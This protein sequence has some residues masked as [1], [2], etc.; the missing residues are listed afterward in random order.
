MKLIFNAQQP[1][2]LS[3]LIADNISKIRWSLRFTLLQSR[4]IIP[5]TTNY[6]RHYASHPLKLIHQGKTPSFIHF[7]LF[8]SG[9]AFVSQNLFSNKLAK[10]V[11]R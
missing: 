8:F 6:Y 1:R 5:A 9:K 10:F 11:Y 2:T 4:S 3:L 7:S